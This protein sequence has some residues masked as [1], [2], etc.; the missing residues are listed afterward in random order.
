MLR[1]LATTLIV[2]VTGS[3][4]LV[5]TAFARLAAEVGSSAAP[6]TVPTT[7]GGT[8]WGEIALA[9]AVAAFVVACA[10]GGALYSRNRRSH[11]ALQA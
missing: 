1:K 9:V 8:P 5:S 10:A 2:V 6:S 3:L 7:G 11:A 4:A